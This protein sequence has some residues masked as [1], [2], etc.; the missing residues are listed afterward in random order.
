MTPHILRCAP[1]MVRVCFHYLFFHGLLQVKPVYICLPEIRK[2]QVI[3][4]AYLAAER[5]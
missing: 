3:V 5:S 4:M 1:A 2:L